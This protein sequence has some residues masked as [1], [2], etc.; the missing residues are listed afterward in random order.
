MAPC[1][2]RRLAWFFALS[3]LLPG[4]AVA[5]S[6]AGASA[7]VTLR[8]KVPP[9]SLGYAYTM[10]NLS[11]KASTLKVDISSV[12]LRGEPAGKRKK[13][14]EMAQPTQSAMA[15]VLSPKPSGDVAARVVV[16]KM[17]IP[18]TKRASKESQELARQ[19]K[20]M[21]G[22]VQL[23]AT[24]T[25]SGLVTSDLKREHRNL[26]AFM[27][28]LPSRPVAVGD[29]WTHS[30]DLVD[31]GK[32]WNGESDTINRV[33]LVSLEREAEG[34]T[35]AVIDFTVAE[36]HAGRYENPALARPLPA[37]MEMS[38]VGRGEFLVEQGRWRRVAGEMATVAKGV[39]SVDSAQRFVMVPL[40]PIPQEVL[41]AQ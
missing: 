39:V 30:A 15:L 5:A 21:E 1:S 9:S 38:Y 2:E 26:V 20:A 36:R 29:V 10:D 35:V 6:G 18:K 19:M 22:R 11:S 4:L 12:R 27:V 3:L 40:E 37:T 25:P 14:F 34:T 31:M 13:L 16:T 7:P 17:E 23:R 41:A 33:E 24:L 28:E 8:W 32:H